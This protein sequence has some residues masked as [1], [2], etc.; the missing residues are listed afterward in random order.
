MKNISFLFFIIFLIFLDCK[1]EKAI[2]KIGRREVDFELLD[3]KLKIDYLRGNKEPDTILNLLFLIEEILNEEIGK[4]EGL[5]IDRKMLKEE[6]E[7]VDKET[8]LPEILEKIK[9]IYKS[10]EEYLEYFIKPL[11]FNQLLQWKF[12]LDTIYHLEDYNY[13]KGLLKKIKSNDT[14]VDTNLVKTF[15][16]KPKR[17]SIDYYLNIYKEDTILQDRYTFFIVKWDNDK[18]NVKFYRKTKKKDYYSWWREKALKFKVKIYNKRYRDLLI[19]KTEEDTF[20][21]KIFGIKK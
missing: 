14:L 5:K 20:Y 16:Y 1:K 9:K 10:E 8:F 18:K 2:M 19:K 15:I 4:R 21:L 11:I 6:K 3:Y 12:Y 7:R 17:E 13:M